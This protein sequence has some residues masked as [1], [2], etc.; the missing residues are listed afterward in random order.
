MEP[1]MKKLKSMK[2]VGTALV[3]SS[4]SLLSACI[5]NIGQPL[6]RGG[7]VKDPKTGLMF[8]SVIENN[9]VTDASFYNNNKIKVRTRNTSGD[10]A[11]GLRE[12]TDQLKDAYSQNG[13]EPTSKNDFGLLIDVN[14]MY[15]GQIQSNLAGEYALLGAAA[16]GIAGVR[17]QA[18]AGTAIGVVAGATLGSILGSFVT[19]DTYIIVADV[20]FGVVKKYKKSK[21]TVTFSN[22]VKLKNLDDPDE[23]DRIINRGFKKTYQTQVSVYAGG[24]NV[25]Q[26]EISGEVRKRI[27]RIVG[28]FI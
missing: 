10:L 7:M 5:G 6:A 18:N 25:S 14:V 3:V 12:F 17:S 24:R 1:S 28:D 11:F 2:F 26:T 21:K 23:D 22:S 8:G 20:T 27:I 15:S 13:Y 19:D 4:L 9:L 16:G